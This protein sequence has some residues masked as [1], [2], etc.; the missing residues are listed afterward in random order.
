MFPVRSRQG[1]V[2]R[3]SRTSLMVC[4]SCV[5]CGVVSCFA[6]LDLVLTCAYAV[7]HCRASANAAAQ[8]ASRAAA[9]SAAHLS[10][11]LANLRELEEAVERWT[12]EQGGD[13]PRKVSR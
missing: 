11:C 2:H 1:I 8:A 4:S 3:K 9:T 12:A 13:A 10:M 5:S 7:H 6:S